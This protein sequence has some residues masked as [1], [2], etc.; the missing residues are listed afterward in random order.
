MFDSGV[1]ICVCVCNC[2]C[3]QRPLEELLQLLVAESAPELP[4]WFVAIDTLAQHL[5]TTPS[6]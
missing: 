1:L 2:C 4:P 6:R 3:R 5:N